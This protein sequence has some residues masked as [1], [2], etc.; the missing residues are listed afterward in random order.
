M[1][2]P[3][4]P[5]NGDDQTPA[6]GT[7]P[8]PARRAPSRATSAATGTPPTGA[9]A[10]RKP[11]TGAAKPP[12]SAGDAAK[13]A[14]KAAA[15]KAPAAKAPAAKS[16]AR[17][18]AGSRAAAKSE[19]AGSLG[20]VPSIL[21]VALAGHNAS[22]RA[23]VDAIESG[24]KAEPAVR[25]EPTVPAEPVVR[26]D[27]TATVVMP[28]AETPTAET[29]AAKTPAAETPATPAA[30]DVPT[31][32]L[33]SSDLPPADGR[34][35][36][37]DGG[38]D[39][40]SDGTAPHPGYPRSVTDFADR[41]D[42][43]RFFSSLFDFSFTHYVTRKLAGPVYVVGLV[44]IALSTLLSIIYSLTLAIETHSVV[45]AFVF[46]FGLIITLVGTMLAIL[47]LRVGIEVFVAI[48]E[49]AQNTRRR[50]KDRQ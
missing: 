23:S 29:P 24:T 2:T 50:K 13:T 48:I 6:E 25:A 22:V 36:T 33:P 5:V 12:A 20:D 43:T 15:A 49:I 28:A 44:L 18:P 1:S 47:L 46:L 39:A 3:Q 10:T 19:Q 32:A 8:A 21:E 31:A 11:A 35:A 40:T 38:G 37:S 27:A 16:A 14:A 7:T 34:D 45:G 42:D 30:S 41:L 9:S 4:P 26:T 17:R